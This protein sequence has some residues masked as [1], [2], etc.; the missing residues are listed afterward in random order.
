MKPSALI[1]A[2]A[3]LVTLVIESAALAATTNDDAT[4]SPSPVALISYEF[5]GKHY[6]CSVADSKFF[7]GP[8]W[9]IENSEP[10]LSPRS[11]LLIAEKEARA[12]VPDSGS[13]RPLEVSLKEFVNIWFYVVTL[14]VN[15][16]NNITYFSKQPLK[17]AVLMDDT[18]TERQEVRQLKNQ[19][20]NA[21]LCCTAAVNKIRL[22]ERHVF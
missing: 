9:K 1:M 14:E 15:A 4:E 16:K 6:F 13:F 19:K 11:A 17:V 21:P 3:F 5:R 20:Y 12:L 8:Q 2:I 10:P 22:D 18:V 7:K